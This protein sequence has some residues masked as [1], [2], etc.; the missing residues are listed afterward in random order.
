M[1]ILLF[2]ALSLTQFS[3]YAKLDLKILKSI[4]RIKSEFQM[5]TTLKVSFAFGCTE[6][7]SLRCPC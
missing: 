7:H 5:M 6:L 4:K 1:H 3:Y 2:T